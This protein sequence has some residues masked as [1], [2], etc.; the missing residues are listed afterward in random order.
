V[1][2]TLVLLKP[3]VVVYRTANTKA[4]NCFVFKSLAFNSWIVK[5]FITG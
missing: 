2:S 3:N 4:C 1:M 5:N